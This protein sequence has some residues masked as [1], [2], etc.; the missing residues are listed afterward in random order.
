[1][2][3]HAGAWE[4]SNFHNNWS[5]LMPYTNY[6]LTAAD[7]GL[8]LYNL[9]YQ[10][11][12]KNESIINLTDLIVLVKQEINVLETTPEKVIPKWMQC[13]EFSRI[14]P[15]KPPQNLNVELKDELEHDIDKLNDL[16][17]NACRSNTK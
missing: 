7:L 16:I 9:S 4:P 3:F 17:R 11:V 13:A 14:Q 1:M 5:I 2:G 8:Q 12:G 6:F 10:A 15:L